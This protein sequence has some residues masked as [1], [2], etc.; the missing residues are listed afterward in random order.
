LAELKEK[1]TPVLRSHGVRRAAVFGSTSRGEDRPDSDI[2]LLVTFG[3]PMG[4]VGYMHF[5]E[6]MENSLHKKVDIV[7]ESSLNKF[8]R[9]HIQADLKTIYEE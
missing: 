1:A 6:Q 9:P 2:D 4:M 8:V 5:I 7:T 3:K